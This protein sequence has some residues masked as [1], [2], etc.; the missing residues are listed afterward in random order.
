MTGGPTGTTEDSAGGCPDGG[1]GEQPVHRVRAGAGQV[2]AAAVDAALGGTT[3]GANG[4][5]ASQAGEAG[6]GRQRSRTETDSAGHTRNCD[7]APVDVAG[8]GLLDDG[9]GSGA[10]EH[11]AGGSAD[12]GGDEDAAGDDHGAAGDVLPVVVEP[13]AGGVECALVGGGVGLE[14]GVG[15]GAQAERV[16][17]VDGEEAAG[18]GV[19]DAGAEPLQ[20]AEGQLPGGA[21]AEGAGEVGGRAHGP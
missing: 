16:E 21:D 1:V 12:A 9:V 2:G 4:H 19:V 15:D 6:P 8:G 20:A 18:G 17:G 10:D 7:L 3:G 5:G 14:L 11:H 13:V